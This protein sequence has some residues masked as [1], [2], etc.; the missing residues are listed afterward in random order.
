MTIKLR[1]IFVL[2]LLAEVS[3]CGYHLV[4]T[5]SFLPEDIETL[6]V[7]KFVNQ[8]KWVD[9]DQRLMEALTLE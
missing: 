5:T 3:G 2:L 9:M 7:E 8:T 1:I 4:G 6:H